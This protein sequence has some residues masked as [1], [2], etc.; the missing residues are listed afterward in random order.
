M[1]DSLHLEKF[2]EGFNPA[3]GTTFSRCIRGFY[4]L[5][6]LDTKIGY[7]TAQLTT[8]IPTHDGLENGQVSVQISGQF[9]VMHHLRLS[10]RSVS[11]GVSV[12]GEVGGQ[13]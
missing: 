4:D 5:Y 13:A 3:G 9:Q 6:P 7:T 2:C 10:S 12:D 11:D 1:T 8:A